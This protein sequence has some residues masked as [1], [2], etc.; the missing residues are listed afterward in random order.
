MAAPRLLPAVLARQA[1]PEPV[2]TLA[3]DADLVGFQGHFPGHPVLPGVVQIHWAAG[4][5]AEAF[6]PLGAFCGLA[7]VKFHQAIGPGRTVDLRLAFDPA[8]G[9]LR[10]A[11]QDG[12]D[13]LSSG[14]VRFRPVQESG[15]HPGDGAPAPPP[16]ATLPLLLPHQPPMRLLDALLTA[17]DQR[18]TALARVDPA[19]WYAG[20]DGS[21]PGW[22]GLEW[23][24][25]A[26][27]AHNGQRRQD[28]G[29]APEFGY[30]LGT[31]AYA[32]DL[33]AFPAHAAAEVEATA[34]ETDPSGLSVYAC[35]IRLHG[36]PVAQALLKVFEP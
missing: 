24:A 3:V 23:M 27:A 30:L 28:P 1:G 21:A 10:F 33:P 22:I 9:Q 2:F 29:V 17:D 11:F 20:P 35:A 31:R 25:Q 32:C 8:R 36:R 14:V 18:C 6:G 5:G 26:V 7:Q 4:F 16:A 12:L 34:Q 15:P 13:L 19:A